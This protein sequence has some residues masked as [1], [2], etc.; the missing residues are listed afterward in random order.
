[1]D[2][3]DKKILAFLQSDGRVSYSTLG[4]EIG[5]TSTSISQRVQKMVDTG[6]I[7]GFGVQLDHTKLGIGIQALISVKLNFTRIESFYSAMKTFEEVEFGYR[8]T[9]ED[10]MVLKVNLRDNTHLLDFI[11]RVSTFGLTETKV[12][13]E[14]VIGR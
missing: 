2:S 8:V 11:N 1:M 6:V 12:I 5:L 4:K 9:G 7:K 14:Q 3:I 13:I 10:C